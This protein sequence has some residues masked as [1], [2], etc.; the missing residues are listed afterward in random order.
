M[1]LP[2]EFKYLLTLSGLNLNRLLCVVPFCLFVFFRKKFMLNIFYLA[3]SVSKCQK[4]PSPPLRPCRSRD[5][6]EKKQM[7]KKMISKYGW[8]NATPNN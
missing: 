2:L 8:K 5:L 6:P 1:F 4:F 7:Y 3:A